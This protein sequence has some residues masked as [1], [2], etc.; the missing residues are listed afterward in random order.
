MVH[1]KFEN[2]EIGEGWVCAISINVTIFA[3][4]VF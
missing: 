2:S 1:P 3:L 4:A